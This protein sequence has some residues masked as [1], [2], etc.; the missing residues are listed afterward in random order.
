[1]LNLYDILQT[2]FISF[3]IYWDVSINCNFSFF[4]ILNFLILIT[5]DLVN[6]TLGHL[7]LKTKYKQSIMR[8]PPT[9]KCF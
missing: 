3:L 2:Q 8:S 1:M 5:R 4:K 7:L 9:S 6:Y